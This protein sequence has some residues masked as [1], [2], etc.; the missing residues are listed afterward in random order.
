MK[1]LLTLLFTL[2]TVLP[3]LSHAQSEGQVP[4]AVEY[5]AL[6]AIYEATGGDNW[7]K[8]DNWL[9]GSTSADFG[10][11]HGVRI[12]NGDVYHLYLS[13]NNLTG[14]IPAELGDL[15][16]MKGDL[17]LSS[18]NLT[19]N[20][21]AELGNLV[22]L[23]R[24]SLNNNNLSGSIPT[25]LGSLASLTYFNLQ[26]NDL[27]GSIAAEL[28]N[29]ANLTGLDLRG[30]DLTG[31]IPAELSKLANLTG[32]WLSHNG[33]TGSIAA[34]LGNLANL[35]S[36]DLR[37][38]DLT[39]NI[40]AELSKLANL[41]GLWL[42]HNGLTGSIPAELDELT[43]LTYLDLRGN[44]LTG[45]IPVELGNLANLTALWLNNNSLT[46][47]I[48]AELSNLTNLTGLW[49]SHNDLTGS[50]PTKLGELANLTRLVL[51]NNNLTGSIP[52]EL[53][54]LANLETLVLYSNQFKD[55]LDFRNSP[56]KSNLQIAI[57]DNIIDLNY[58][59]ANLSGVDTHPFKD[60]LY[61]QN[62]PTDTIVIADGATIDLNNLVKQHPQTSYQWQ[63]FVNGS[64]Q[65]IEGA[66][67]P[68]YQVPGNASA[69]LYR[70]Q[71]TNNWL[72]GMQQYSTMFKLTPGSV[73]TQVWL[74]AE[75]ADQVGEA[76]QVVADSEASGDSYLQVQPGN[77]S[78]GAAPTDAS[79]QLTFTFSVSQAGEYTLYTVFS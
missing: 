38:N 54:K 36:L 53:S 76:W 11:W 73:A 28:G 26:Q 68:T 69:T 25:E 45:S 72:P 29:L 14:S 60:F 56:N 48:P 15:T 4:D 41:T 8:N 23:T 61:S 63:H 3:T 71:L 75:C 31:S 16:S 12:R 2:L 24:L 47:S 49:L 9:Q 58:I 30:N 67:Q 50:I 32:L 27:T 79:K 77:S 62:S 51:N 43:N 40:P 33:L 10:T 78:I 35:T 59:A 42:S 7:T 64:W 13:S 6:K 19:G 52:A 70:C 17:F 37:V 39:G 21:P 74:E 1:K 55:F 66:T 22:N 65:G 44:D 34:E 57:M 5:A 20:I 46:G 18:N